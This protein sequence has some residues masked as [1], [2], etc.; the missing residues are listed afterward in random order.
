METYTIDEVRNELNNINNRISY[1]TGLFDN[2]LDYSDIVKYEKELDLLLENKTS[3][4]KILLKYI[5]KHPIHSI[6]QF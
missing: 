6:D 4:Q 3:Y 1:L 5:Y 2:K